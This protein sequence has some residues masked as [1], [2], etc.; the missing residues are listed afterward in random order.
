MVSFHMALF[1][2]IKYVYFHKKYSVV[3]L[4]PPEKKQ[5][6]KKHFYF[7]FIE[8]HTDY[9]SY[10]VNIFF[11]SGHVQQKNCKS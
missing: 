10:T 5:G 3:Y 2:G 7:I 1:T 6:N 4:F 8:Y 9:T 11:I